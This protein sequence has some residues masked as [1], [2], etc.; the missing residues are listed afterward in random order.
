[1]YIPKKWRILSGGYLEKRSYL[2]NRSGLILSGVNGVHGVLDPRRTL[3]EGCC[4]MF[5]EPTSI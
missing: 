1:M 4:S 5:Y 2:D 3:K